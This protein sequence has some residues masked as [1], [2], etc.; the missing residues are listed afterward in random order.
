MIRMLLVEDD[1]SLGA[2]L[3]EQ[4]ERKGYAVTWAQ[5]LTEARQEIQ[6]KSWNLFILDIGL[7]DGT[8]FQLVP[9]IR[10]KY[11]SAAIIFLTALNT[12]ENRLMGY[13]QG[14]D[15]FI[16][17]PF[18][19]K[20]LFIRI[21]HV[22]KHRRLGQRLR[23]GAREIDWQQMGVI[24]SDGQL[25]PLAARDFEVLAF[26]IHSAPKVVSRDDILD[27]VWGADQFPSTR[28]VDNI[29]VRLRQALDDKEGRWIRS[30]RGV[31]YQ[32]VQDGE[33]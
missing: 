24:N 26:L 32:W 28:T 18:H 30:V 33:G 23:C 2:T 27:E 25:L 15:E 7:P 29:M 22:I 17:K 20:E 11:N 31:G 4:L 3:K 10:A 1:D 5:N 9:D 16:P 13:D 19:L 12:A 21:E 8:G 14:A 6:D